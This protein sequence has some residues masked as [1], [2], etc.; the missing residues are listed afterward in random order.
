MY[1][2]EETFSVPLF[3]HIYLISAKKFPY[4]YQ[5]RAGQAYRITLEKFSYKTPLKP[6]KGLSWEF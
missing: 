5:V 1:N 4:I 3:V 6:I 2:K